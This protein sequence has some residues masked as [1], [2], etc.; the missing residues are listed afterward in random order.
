[1]EIS[2]LNHGDAVLVRTTT[3]R[4]F[5]VVVDYLVFD[6]DGE[7]IG[8]VFSSG[9]FLSARAIRS[10]ALITHPELHPD[11]CELCGTP[12]DSQVVYEVSAPDGDA[13]FDS[14]EECFDYYDGRL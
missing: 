6:R 7:P 9:L 11:A 14:C 12:L 3:A 4:M 10:V 1:M 8:V 13:L 5:N 2:Q